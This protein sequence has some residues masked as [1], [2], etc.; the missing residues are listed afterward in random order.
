[1]KSGHKPSAKQRKR[2]AR[3]VDACAKVGV[4]MPSWML[5]SSRHR[6]D[7]LGYS[8]FSSYVQALIHQDITQGKAHTRTPQPPR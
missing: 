8:T 1:M 6:S 4:S 2:D 7:E 5:E 3:P